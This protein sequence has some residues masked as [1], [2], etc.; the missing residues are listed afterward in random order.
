MLPKI[1]ACIRFLQNSR[2]P[3]ARTLITNPENIG[4]ALRGE[5]G[6]RIVR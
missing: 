4:R 6:T 2:K 1:E 3:N 5:T